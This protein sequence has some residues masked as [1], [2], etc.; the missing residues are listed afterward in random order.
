MATLTVYTAA[1]TDAGLITE[2]DKSLAVDYNKVKIIEIR[3]GDDD[4]L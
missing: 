1:F 4:T 2:V 3:G